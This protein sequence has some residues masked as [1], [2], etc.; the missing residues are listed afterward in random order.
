MT[1]QAVIFDL[2]G[3]VLDS[4]YP[5][6]QEYE[7]SHGLPSH[8]IV[9]VVGRSLSRANGP[10]QRL[11]KGEILLD[12]FCRVFD[13]ELASQGHTLST[14]EIM[15]EMAN[16]MLPREAMVSAVR[17]V[18]AAGLKTVGLSNTWEIGDPVHDERNRLRDEFDLYLASNEVRM[19]KPE[20]ALL[21]RVCDELTLAPE[22]IVY[23]DEVGAFLK[24]AAKLGMRTIRVSEP[25]AAIGEL[26]SLLGIALRPNG[27]GSHDGDR[28]NSAPTAPADTPEE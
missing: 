9:D 12:E 17:A 2:G 20:V 5:T 19:R 3:V 10:Q 7:A 23:L 13:E 24:P 1:V 6:L 21:T 14:A 15:V 11:E 27:T 22:D 26:E 4:A 25:D 8:F 16:N 28:A 18:R